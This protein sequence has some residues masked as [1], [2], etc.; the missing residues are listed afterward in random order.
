MRFGINDLDIRFPYFFVQHVAFGRDAVP[1][2]LPLRS[3]RVRVDVIC[4]H[5]IENRSLY[6]TRVVRIQGR[7]SINDLLYFFPR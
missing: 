2:Q 1:I 4:V 3:F 5:Q 7:E 6:S